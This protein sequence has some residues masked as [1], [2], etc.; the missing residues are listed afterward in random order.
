MNPFRYQI[1]LQLRH[2]T[3]GASRPLGCL[4]G[5]GGVFAAGVIEK[6]QHP[7]CARNFTEG[8][9]GLERLPERQRCSPSR[10]L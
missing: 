4:P 7:G 1:P 6:A 8:A 3:M 5:T 10:D 2:S 9:A